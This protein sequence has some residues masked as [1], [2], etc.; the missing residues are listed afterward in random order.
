MNASGRF[1]TEHRKPTRRVGRRMEHRCLQDTTWWWRSLT[2]CTVVVCTRLVQDR[3]PDIS[4][5]LEEGPC[6]GHSFFSF[7]RGQL[8]V[9]IRTERGQVMFW[10]KA[11]LHLVMILITSLPPLFPARGYGCMRPPVFML[12]EADA[13][14][15]QMLITCSLSSGVPCLH[16]PCLLPSL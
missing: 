5:W 11:V 2:H 9:R 13:T 16:L 1:F 6:R 14:R 10:G 4:L 15:S 7:S 12:G 8:F 3:T